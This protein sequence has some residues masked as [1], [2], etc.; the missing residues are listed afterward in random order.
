MTKITI[1]HKDCGNAPRM[2]VIKEFLIALV[3]N[4]SNTVLNWL[5]DEI[6]W[7]NIGGDRL[8][9]KKQASIA[10]ANLFSQS[11]SELYLDKIIAHG[12]MAAAQGTIIFEDGK[13]NSFADIYKFAGHSK[14]ARIKEISPYIITIEWCF[15]KVLNLIKSK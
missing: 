14:T 15:Q 9:G 12:N 10:L 13:V 2:E 4:D 8:E 6:I 11:P 7:D 3:Q 1:N 5:D